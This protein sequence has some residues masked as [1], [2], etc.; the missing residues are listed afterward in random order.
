[1]FP[2]PHSFDSRR[3]LP[4]DGAA[5]VFKKGGPS[6][7]RRRQ[8]HIVQPDTQTVKPASK[9]QDCRPASQSTNRGR[10]A[11]SIV[12]LHSFDSRRFL[13]K[14]GAA[15]VFKKGGRGPISSGRLCVINAQA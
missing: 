13:P 11:P 15:P 14:D 10:S 5:P 4:K 6:S 7:L 9:G 2:D 3:F 12:K 1:M 8:P